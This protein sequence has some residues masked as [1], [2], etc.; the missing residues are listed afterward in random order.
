MSEHLSAWFAVLD[1]LV[2][3]E[4]D[5]VSCG[6]SM[7]VRISAS[8]ALPRREASGRSENHAD[9]GPGKSPRIL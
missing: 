5:W 2:A 9:D 7:R 8:R 6:A 1:W 4:P 3:T